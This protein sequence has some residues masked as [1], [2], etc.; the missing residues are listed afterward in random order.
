MSDTPEFHLVVRRPS[1]RGPL[2]PYRLTIS[3]VFG[4]VL[5]GRRMLT[6]AETGVGVDSSMLLFG[7]STLFAWILVGVLSKLLAGSKPRRATPAVVDEVPES[8]PTPLESA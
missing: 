6:A 8:T 1:Q 4:L 7:G 2:A 3:V 5:A